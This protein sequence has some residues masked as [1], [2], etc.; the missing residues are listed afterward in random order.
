SRQEVWAEFYIR[1]SS[2]FTNDNA[3]CYP[4]DHKLIFGETEG[5]LSLRWGFHVGMDGD[6]STGTTHTIGWD[7]PLGSGFP[8]EGL[9][10]PLRANNLWDGNWHVL[11]FHIKNST[12]GSSNDGQ[13]EQWIDGVRYWNVT[14]FSNFKDS[15]TFTPDLINAFSFTHNLDDGPVGVLMNI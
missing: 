15:V 13:I 1:W 9:R 2:N 5:P 8:S 7:Y 14:G 4:N 3:T 6:V 12:T 11:R 10:Y